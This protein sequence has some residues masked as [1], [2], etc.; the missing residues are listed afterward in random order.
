MDKEWQ[1]LIVAAI[2]FGTCNTRMAFAPKPLVNT[3]ESLEI[4]VMDDWE[5]SPGAQKAPTSVLMDN[6]QSVIAYGY[7]AEEMFRTLRLAERRSSYLFKN[8]KMDLHKKAVR[9]NVNYHR[10]KQQHV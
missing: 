5:H 7:E 4:I 3:M 10:F 9:L 1:P 6:S 2:D 8:F